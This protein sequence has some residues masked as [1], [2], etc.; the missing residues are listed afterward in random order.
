MTKQLQESFVN[1][2]TEI[3]RDIYRSYFVGDGE[4]MEK[5]LKIF[6]SIMPKRI[7]NAIKEAWSKYEEELG[8]VR[9]KLNDEGL[10]EQTRLYRINQFKLN[11]LSGILDALMTECHEHRIFM[12]MPFSPLGGMGTSVT[13]Q[14]MKLEPIREAK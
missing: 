1:L 10:S 7:K 5:A 13:R 8:E 3:L 12:S 9:S 6:I 11:H 14:P 2:V 4:A